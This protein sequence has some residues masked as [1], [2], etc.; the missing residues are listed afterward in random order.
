[1]RYL[2]SLL[3]KNGDIL[4]KNYYDVRKNQWTWDSDSNS[5]DHV[6]N[7]N[8]LLGQHRPLFN[9]EHDLPTETALTV[10]LK[11]KLLTSD[12]NRVPK[13]LE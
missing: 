13:L 6:L 4:E 9:E 3:L 11:H 8:P 1:M 7:M 10:W 5:T 12:V 2:E